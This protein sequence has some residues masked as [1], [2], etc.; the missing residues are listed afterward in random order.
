M[1]DVVDGRSMVGCE[2]LRPPDEVLPP[3]SPSFMQV[4]MDGVRYKMAVILK[5]LEK[6]TETEQNS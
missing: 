3:P 5:S 4:E 1:P 2:M 6:R